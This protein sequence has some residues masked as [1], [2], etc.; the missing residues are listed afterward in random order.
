MR[1]KGGFT[2]TM[3]ALAL[4]NKDFAVCVADDGGDAVMA[5]YALRRHGWI[6]Q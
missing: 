5:C 6:W 4:A 1:V 3:A 2:C